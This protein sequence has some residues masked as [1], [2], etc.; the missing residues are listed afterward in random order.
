[1]SKI[2]L[3]HVANKVSGQKAADL[4]MMA[5][6]VSQFPAFWP[7]APFLSPALMLSA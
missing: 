1:M 6:S 5:I 3:W 2:K 7:Y 4:L